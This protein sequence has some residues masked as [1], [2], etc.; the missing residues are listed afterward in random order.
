MPRPVLC[1]SDII[2]RFET[3]EI[4]DYSIVLTYLESNQLQHGVIT[5]SQDPSVKVDIFCLQKLRQ[6]RQPGLVCL[7]QLLSAKYCNLN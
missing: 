4:D 7:L 5:K 2:T 3:G 6:M 1:I